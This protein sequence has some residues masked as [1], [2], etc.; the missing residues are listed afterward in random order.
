[1]DA[2]SIVCVGNVGCLEAV[3]GGAASPG[4]L[5]AVARSGASRRWPI[6]WPRRRVVGPGCSP[7]RG[8][9]PPPRLPRLRTVIRDG[10]RQLGIVLAGLVRFTIHHDCG[11]RRSFAIGVTCCSPRSAASSTQRSY[12]WR[13]EISYRDVRV[14]AS[15]PSSSA[16]SVLPVRWP[17][18]VRS[19]DGGLHSPTDRDILRAPTRGTVPIRQFPVAAQRRLAATTPVLAVATGSRIPEFA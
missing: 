10:G 17:T 5:S 16:R 3:F 12:H 4:T 2:H 11:R 15:V 6:G 18:A 19:I 13:P 8:V 7:P 14:G 1:V 9:M